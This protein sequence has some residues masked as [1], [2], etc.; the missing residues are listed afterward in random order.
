MPVQGTAT[1]G[2]QKALKVHSAILQHN[3]EQKGY[4]LHG[5]GEVVRQVREANDAR[6]VDAQDDCHKTPARTQGHQRS[7]K[8]HTS[9][10]H[11]GPTGRN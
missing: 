8:H 3:G 1:P 6:D 5:G 4:S 9:T 11:G 7:E 2:K 10:A